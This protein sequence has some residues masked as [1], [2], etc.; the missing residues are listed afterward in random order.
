MASSRLKLD[1][2]DKLAKKGTELAK[3]GQKATKLAVRAGAKPITAR[4]KQNVPVETGLL[5]DSIGERPRD[6]RGSGTS[7]V[8]IGPRRETSGIGPDGRK[9]IPGKYAHLVEYGT[10][11]SAPQSFMRKGFE[12]AKGVAVA[13][14]RAVYM[15]SIRGA[16]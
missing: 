12:Q 14:M 8:V 6:Y 9:R 16:L 13:A 15:A 11:F 1:G 3:I 5:R 2:L 4:I 7:I 10:Q